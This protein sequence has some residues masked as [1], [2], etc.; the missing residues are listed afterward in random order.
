MLARRIA[1]YLIL[2]CASFSAAFAYGQ[3]RATIARNAASVDEDAPDSVQLAALGIHPGVQIVAYVFGA[4]RCGFCQKPQ[5]KQ[6]VRAL[7]DSL[8]KRQLGVRGV[9][10]VRVVGVAVNSD[11]GEGLGYLRGVGLASFDEI[12]TGSGWQNEHLVRLVGQ[13]RAAQAG[14]PLVVVTARTMSASL[15][16]LKMNYGSDSLLRVVQGSDAIASWVRAG[17]PLSTLC[18]QEN[19]RFGC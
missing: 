9:A 6:A 5:T 13:R 17:A 16:P 15:M 12:D 1:T 18:S 4:A 10:S 19:T 8:S 3:R 14:L 2:C 11:V 7:R